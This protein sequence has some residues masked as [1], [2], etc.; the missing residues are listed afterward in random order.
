MSDNSGILGEILEQ[1][2]STVKQTGQQIKQ[3]PVDLAK[4]VKN[5]VAGGD[6]SLG[7][8]P[9]EE[10]DKGKEETEQLVRDIYKPGEEKSAAEITRNKAKDAAK[11]E[12]TRAKLAAH[13]RYF[14]EEFNR[15]KPKE[16]KKADE[17]ERKK[18][19]EMVDLQQKEKKKPPPLAV[20]MGAQKTEKYPGASG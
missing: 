3:M 6:K 5:Q 13:Q 8:A 12:K 2:V 14:Q 1:G 11:L 10:A 16:E 19:Q 7:Q 9:L 4:S 20:R 18:E 15:P 17:L